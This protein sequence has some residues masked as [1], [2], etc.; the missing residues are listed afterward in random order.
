M[1]LAPLNYDRFFKKVFSDPEI[2]KKF[3]EDFLD[4]TI[5]EFE[6]L[7][8]RHRITDDATLVEFD[9]RCKIKGAYVI[10]DMQQ[11][12][13]RDIGQRFYLYHALNT[14]LQLEKLPERNLIMDR[15]TQKLKKVK[16]YRSLEPVITLIWMVDDTLGFKENYV[17]YCMTPELVVDFVR[18]DKLWRK[19][20]FVELLKTRTSILDVL[21]NKKKGMPFLSMNRLIFLLQGNIVKNKPHT[22]YERWFTF[23][24]RTRN[25]KNNEQDFEEYK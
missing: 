18:N 13:K 10:I 8:G 17:S 4:E 15:V 22:R 20:D 16:D 19:P 23:A 7:N 9:Y 24:E 11:W 12:Y 14:G 3:L 1:Y 25:D 5:E 21:K 6:M 2:A